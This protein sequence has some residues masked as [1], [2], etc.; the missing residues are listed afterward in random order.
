[1]VYTKWTLLVGWPN[2][3]RQPQFL[4]TLSIDHGF[5]F[6]YSGDVR[7]L[8]TFA[9][10]APPRVNQFLAIVKDSPIPNRNQP[11]QSPHPKHHLESLSRSDPRLAAL[12]TPGPGSQQLGTVPTPQSPL[13]LF[14]LANPNS[15]NLASPV[16]SRGNHRK[17]S[18]T[19]FPLGPSAPWPA[20][21]LP[22]VPPS[23]G[24]RG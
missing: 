13:R 7:G 4:V 19:R 21:M 17:G 22:W 6:L 9:V 11:I 24:N 16:P 23:L 20:L 8:A 5:S 3:Y 18:C 15:V 14:Q 1:M 2:P 12:N 10:T